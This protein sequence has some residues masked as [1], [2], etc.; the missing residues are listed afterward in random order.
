MKKNSNTNIV[1][2]NVNIIKTKINF[3]KDVIEEQYFI[4]IKINY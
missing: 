1:D 2:N 3:F 4:F